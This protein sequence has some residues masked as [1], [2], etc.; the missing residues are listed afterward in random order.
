[1]LLTREKIFSFIED[2]FNYTHLEVIPFGEH[3]IFHADFNVTFDDRGFI[4]KFSVLTLKVKLPKAKTSDVIR[5]ES[6]EIDCRHAETIPTDTDLEI[7]R[8]NILRDLVDNRYT[9]IKLKH[10]EKVYLFDDNYD[11]AIEEAAEYMSH[12]YRLM[13]RKGK[14]WVSVSDDN[15]VFYFHIFGSFS[16][17]G[18]YKVTAVLAVRGE[19]E[20]A[21]AGSLFQVVGFDVP[22]EISFT[23]LDILRGYLETSTKV[24]VVDKDTIRLQ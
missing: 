1:M 9:D 18:L 16:V 20:A 19:V 17:Y 22:K 10:E 3:L 6:L 24:K 21:Q 13:P 14:S 2:N 5:F 8:S 4:H 12:E 15:R 23:N 7:L 11:A